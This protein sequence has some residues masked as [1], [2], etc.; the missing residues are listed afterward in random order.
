MFAICLVVS[1]AP[2]TVETIQPCEGSQTPCCVRWEMQRWC[3]M[4]GTSVDSG[5]LRIGAMVGWIY[6]GFMVGFSLWLMKI[7]GVLPK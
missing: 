7:R 6:R 5:D 4:V 1:Q 3:R 2:S